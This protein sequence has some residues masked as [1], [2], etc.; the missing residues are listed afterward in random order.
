MKLSNQIKS[1]IEN[2]TKSSIKSL[3]S[4][5]GGC[6]SDAYKLIMSS[7][8]SF[9]L[10]L[11]NNN[12]GNMF[13]KEAHGLNELNKS[14]AIRVPHVIQFNETYILIE[15]ISPGNRSRN[16]FEDFGH[17]FAEMHKYL[18]NTF[19]FYE[20]NFIGSNIQENV[21]DD[22]EKENWTK[23]YFNNRI[24]FQLKLAEKN[25]F[26]TKELASKI[27]LL[28]DKIEKIL[29]GSKEKPSLLHGDLWGGN[30]IVDEKGNAALIDPAVYYGHR[31]ADLAMTKLFGGF[32]SQFYEAYNES[33]PLSSG[34][35][36]REN[37]YK[38]YHVLNHLNLFGRGYYPQVISLIDF[39]IK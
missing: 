8:N 16:F 35:E 2:V 26:A 29:N 19:G 34:Y 14:N 23:F 7:G 33:F 37:I 27:N 11:N 20:N 28:E 12:P 5:S 18:G 24:L 9:F 10:K 22:D 6:I 25:G 36:F 39:Y 30:Y 17:K 3:E 13:E 4:I 15:F 21:A 31:E 38:L 1:E 32:S